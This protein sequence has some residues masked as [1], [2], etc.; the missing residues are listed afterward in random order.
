MHRNTLYISFL[1]II[2]M[3]ILQQQ[4]APKANYFKK[5]FYFFIFVKKFSAYLFYPRTLSTLPKAR[6]L[7]YSQM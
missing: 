6:Q 2:K 7:G 5:L 4:N 3:S 1:L